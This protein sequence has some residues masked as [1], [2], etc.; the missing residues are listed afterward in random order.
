[1]I[2]ISVQCVHWCELRKIKHLFEETE[3]FCY[4]W[5]DIYHSKNWWW[6]AAFVPTLL[7]W[8]PDTCSTWIYLLRIIPNNTNCLRIHI[9]SQC[10]SRNLPLSNRIYR[11]DRPSLT[12]SPSVTWNTRAGSMAGAVPRLTP[13]YNGRT[14]GLMGLSGANCT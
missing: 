6:V 12:R 1:M 8:V 10:Y 7:L 11:S 3:V 2:N 13:P 14:I 4:Q 9:Y 5:G